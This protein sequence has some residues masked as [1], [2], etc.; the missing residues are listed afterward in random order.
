M[1]LLT[2]S[3]SRLITESFLVSLCFMLKVAVAV[4]LP[5]KVE[6]YSRAGV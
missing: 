4:S 6:M 3:V 1:L 5:E 2:S